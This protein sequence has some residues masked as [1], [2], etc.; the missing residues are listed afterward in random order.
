MKNYARWSQFWNNRLNPDGTTGY[1]SAPVVN[2]QNCTSK[3]NW[4]AEGPFENSVGWEGVG[5]IQSIAVYEQ[6]HQIVYIGS[7]TGGVFKSTDLGLSW[8]SIFNDSDKRIT[9]LGVLDIIIHPTNPDIVLIAT[10]LNSP[11][12]SRYGAGIYKTINGGDTWTNVSTGFN[13]NPNSNY[14]LV[15]DLAFEVGN[16]NIVYASYESK[17]MKSTDGGDS[18]TVFRTSQN[19]MFFDQIKCIDSG[20]DKLLYI[21][22]LNDTATTPP[23]LWR[24][25]LNSTIWTNITPPVTQFYRL[26]IDVSPAEPNSIFAEYKHTLFI[27]NNRGSTYTTKPINDANGTPMWGQGDQMNA[28]AVSPTNTNIMY[29]GGFWAHKSTD[30]GTTFPHRYPHHSDLRVMTYISS[31]SSGFNDSILIGH[32]GGIDLIVGNSIYNRNNNN[33]NVTQAWDCTVPLYSKDKLLAIGTQDNGTFFYRNGWRY[34]PHFVSGGD[35]GTS[36]FTKYNGVD[37]IISSQ[38]DNIYLSNIA[39]S[40]PKPIVEDICYINGFNGDLCFGVATHTRPFLIN[41]QNP[42]SFYW[43]LWD[44]FRYNLSASS[45]A[46][47]ETN[48]SNYQNNS[49]S[50]FSPHTITAMAMSEMDTNIIYVATQFSQ[51]SD[52]IF[53]LPNYIDS[54]LYKTTNGGI[55]WT[56]ISPLGISRGGAKI[57]SIAIN[58]SNHNQIWVAYGGFRDDTS[59]VNVQDKIYTST[60]GGSTWENY[61]QGLQNFPVNEIIYQ[62]ESNDRLYIAT[63]LGVFYR[64]ASM[65]QWECFN[66]GLPPVITTGLSINYCTGKIYA[67]TYGR[68]LWSGDILSPDAVPVDVGFGS[69]EHW[70]SDTTIKESV[71]IIVGGS[72]TITNATVKMMHGAKIIVSQDAHLVMNNSKIT[73]ECDAFWAGIEVWGDSK[74]AKNSQYCFSSNGCKV[75]KITMN[76]STLENAVNAVSLWNPADW[77]MRGGMIFAENS[78]FINNCRDVVFMAF[79]NHNSNNAGATVRPYRSLFEN[80]T[81]KIDDNF[82]FERRE[83]YPARVTMWQVR[84]V[85]FNG[86]TFSNQTSNRYQ[87]AGI[88]SWDANFTVKEFIDPNQSVITPSTFEGFAAGIDA[89]SSGLG[90]SFTV[91]TSHFTNCYMG[92]VANGVNNAVITRNW[93]KK[94]ASLPSIVNGPSGGIYLNGADQFIVTENNIDDCLYGIIAGS[95]GGARNRIYRNGIENAFYGNMAAGDNNDPNATEIGLNYS[96]NIHKSPGIYDMIV[97]GGSGIAQYQGSMSKAAN[98]TFTPVVGS[99]TFPFQSIANPTPNAAIINYYHHQNSAGYTLEPGSVDAFTVVTTLASGSFDQNNNCLTSISHFKT[100]TDVRGRMTGLQSLNKRVEFDNAR[101]AHNQA[102]YVYTSTLNGGDTYDLL[103]TVQTTN[104]QDA[105]ALRTELINSSPLSE[106]VIL[107]TIDEDVLSNSLLLDVL[108]VNGQA[109]RNEEIIDLLETKT[110]PMPAYMINIFLGLFELESQEDVL[111]SQVSQESGRM[112]SAAR[113]L[114]AHW[115]A[116]TTGGDLDSIPPLLAEIGNPLT[117]LQWVAFQR[118]MNKKAEAAGVLN[119]LTTNY[120]LTPWQQTTING[121]K[122]IYTLYDASLANAQKE[123]L[124]LPAST[125]TTLEQLSINDNT[126]EGIYAK[127]WLKFSQN[128]LYLP[129]LME[130]SAPTNKTETHRIF[131]LREVT[132]NTIFEVYP[133]PAHN[134]LSISTGEYEVKKQLQL[135]IVNS[136]G[137]VVIHQI[138]TPGVSNINTSTLPSGIYVLNVL[139]GEEEIQKQVVEII[140]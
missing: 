49:P 38:N 20:V 102:K 101:T 133:N 36:I 27:S 5:R 34:I 67:S 61:S 35:G 63:D 84:G 47:T 119:N 68:G 9:G 57:S 129:E 93:I 51:W 4:E 60:N 42:K 105:W 114:L 43:G 64:D 73:N 87:Y 44:V 74:Y 94:D 58:P 125:K 99:S 115:Y 16:P 52:S 132:E 136:L 85:P 12:A 48:I 106:E 123:V 66:E 45:I 54:S 13:L 126:R 97:L 2:F 77:G 108:L 124:E 29:S 90:Y 39:L 14:Y 69:G 111:L 31:D 118:S 128:E 15:H 7:N 55:S 109:S 79:E 6:N 110:T 8:T 75:G 138:I 91:D 22:V 11:L 62:K 92:V 76:N 83:P 78:T 135:K 80:C 139:D 81:F 37:Y 137:M 56:G 40:S 96:C 122:N 127:S 71:R 65:S 17:L 10:G 30:Q 26:F 121:V 3:G 100:E 140:R 32:D 112:H 98:N 72:V 59:T 23:Q 25:D 46:N 89:T 1:T 120:S 95:T 21:T 117:D 50:Y 113:L 33:L 130:Y 82:L 24:C 28:L 116:D 19:G 104:A 53:N 70:T 107:E 88:Y 103:N 41:T 134:V 86:C 131:K 18:F